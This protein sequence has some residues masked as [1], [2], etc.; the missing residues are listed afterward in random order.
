MTT[1]IRALYTRLPAT[2]RLLRD[3]AF[4]AVLARYGHAQV[5]ALLRQMLEEA[6]EYI[7]QE[8]ALPGWCDDWPQE[9]GRRLAQTGQSALRPVFNLTGTVLHTNL[10]R[11]IQA[12]AAVEA[13]AQAMRAPVTLEYS[14]D[15]A[16]R[17]HRDRALADL[18]C[19]ITGAED[20]CIV[21]NNAAAV[22]L[23]LAATAGG[24]EVVLA[25]RAGGDRRRI[26]YSRC[27]APGGL[28][29]A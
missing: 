20:A 23:M 1:D 3:P 17:G 5:V 8:Q 29:P 16:G 2:D 15:D 12:E 10:G 14:L 9:T 26:P 24:K 27:D 18:L 21:N 28:H 19:R 4:S 13:V 25:R 22:L 7:R 6:R 11:A